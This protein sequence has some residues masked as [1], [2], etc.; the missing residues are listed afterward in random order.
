MNSYVFDQKTKKVA[1]HWGPFNSLI[2]TLMIFCFVECNLYMIP[3]YCELGS[4]CVKFKLSS[5]Q[6]LTHAM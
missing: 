1:F 2:G 6:S 4:L 5:K 3:C